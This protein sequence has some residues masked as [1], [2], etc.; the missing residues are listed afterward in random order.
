MPRKDKKKH[1]NQSSTLK[2]QALTPVETVRT[3]PNQTVTLYDAKLELALRREALQLAREEMVLREEKFLHEKRMRD[4]ERLMAAEEARDRRMLRAMQSNSWQSEIHDVTE[5]D[6]TE[7]DMCLLL[8]NPPA[9]LNPYHPNTIGA[10]A[11]EAQRLKRLDQR[12]VFP[13][14]EAMAEGPL[15]SLPQQTEQAKPSDGGSEPLLSDED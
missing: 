12:F 3:D 9:M 14:E 10:A 7:G 4:T 5:R 2:H 8:Q 11:G 6:V 13:Q 15:P 1:P